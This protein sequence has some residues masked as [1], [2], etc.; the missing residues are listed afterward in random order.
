LTT[1]TVPS[2][3]AAMVTLLA[4]GIAVHYVTSKR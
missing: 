3:E 1:T 4:L 2:A